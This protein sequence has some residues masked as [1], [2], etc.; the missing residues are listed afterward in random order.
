VS[1]DVV[2]GVLDRHGPTDGVGDLVGQREEVRGR[3][4]GEAPQAPKPGVAGRG[5]EPVEMSPR[6]VLWRDE[7]GDPELVTGLPDDARLDAGGLHHDGG[8]VAP[9]CLADHV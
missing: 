8:A 9:R 6:H 1:Q 5:D 7:Y 4:H 3:P 2:G